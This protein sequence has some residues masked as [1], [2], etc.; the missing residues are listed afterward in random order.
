LSRRE[1]QDVAQATRDRN[2]QDCLDGSD[3]CAR[4]QLDAMERKEVADAAEY[5]KFQN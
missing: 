4:A 1:Q 3:F 5:R 2:L